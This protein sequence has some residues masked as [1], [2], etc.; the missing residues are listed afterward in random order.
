V[1]T[2]LFIS[3]L[4]RSYT[5]CCSFGTVPQAQALPFFN[6]YRHNQLKPVV[7]NLKIFDVQQQ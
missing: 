1:I 3:T 2:R 5:S 7:F 4:P 6:F